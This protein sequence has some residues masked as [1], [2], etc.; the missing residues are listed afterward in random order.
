MH[1]FFYQLYFIIYLYALRYKCFFGNDINELESLL[2]DT[3][4]YYEAVIGPSGIQ[5]MMVTGPSG[6]QFG[7]LGIYHKLTT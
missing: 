5:F 4:A 7:L 1:V 3:S 6:V 2:I